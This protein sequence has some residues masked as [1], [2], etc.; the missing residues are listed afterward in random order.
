M[1]IMERKSRKSSQGVV[2]GR[3]GDKSVKVVYFYKVPHG[4]YRKE[5][6]S[7]T[8]FH[9]HDKKNECLDKVPHAAE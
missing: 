4:L 8:G 2:M 6:R 5:V 7:K 9:V 3:S 1:L